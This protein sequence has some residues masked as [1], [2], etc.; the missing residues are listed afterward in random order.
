MQK[1]EEADGLPFACAE[2]RTVLGQNLAEGRHDT[3]CWRDTLLQP[4][5][6]NGLACDLE[7]AWDWG[8]GVL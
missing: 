2:G 8:Q 1:M 7:E 5:G 3:G 4:G 6:P